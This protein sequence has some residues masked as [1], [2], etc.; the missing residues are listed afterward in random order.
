MASL[1]IGDL[2]AFYRDA[3]AKFDADEA[4]R[5]RSRTRVVELQAGDPETRRLW[6]VLVDQSVAYFSEVYEMLDVTL[7]RDD[8]VGESSYNERL[9]EVVAELDAKGLLV[10]SGGALCVFPPGFTNREGEPLPLIVQKRDEGYGY[11]ATDLAALRDRVERL[12]GDVLL[13]VVGTPQAQHF[14]M[15][16]AAARMAGWL[17]AAVRCEHVAFGNVLGPDHK[18]FKTRSGETVKLAALLDEATQRARRGARERP[19]GPRG[20]ER[21]VLASQIA[22]AAIKYA[23]LSTE[24]QR[25]YVFDLDRM[26][27]FEGDTGPYLQYAHARVRSI[28]RRLG[29]PWD[30]RAVLRPDQPARARPGPRAPGAARGG[31]RARWR[32]TSRTGSAPICSTWPSA[33]PRSTKHARSCRRGRAARRAPGAV[34]PHLAHAGPGAV[35]ARHRRARADVATRA[36]RGLGRVRLKRAREVSMQVRAAVITEKDG[37]FL[38]ETIEIDEPHAHEVKVKMAYAGMCYSDESLRSGGIDLP[39]AAPGH[40]GSR[41]QRYPAV[42]GHEGSGV[43]ESVGEGVTGLAPGDHVADVLHPLVRHV[44]VLPFR[45]PV[46]LRHGGHHRRGPDD[47]RRDLAP[48]P[49]RHQPQPH[50]PARRVLRVRRRPRGVADQDRPVARPARGRAHLVRDLDRLRV[51]GQSRRRQGRRRRSRSSDAEASDRCAAR[52]VAR[53]SARGA[54]RSTPNPP[55]SS[56]HSSTARRTAVRRAGRGV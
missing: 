50:V 22:R 56:A 11:A 35:A 38:T 5:D 17:P 15:V 28:F 23:D 1:S 36:P 12:G 51:S 25:D 34:R 3:R 44:R 42:G 30:A 48:P 40:L 32:P 7:S 47:H 54:S 2:D 27:A 52:R 19:S 41:L 10:E 45:S 39:P 53:R 37:P 6:R 26:L 16:F 31:G 14:E 43:V 24:R 33:S 49:G 21:D 55:R 29:E 9:D 46:H 20:D 4:F 8:V 18:M 13:Y